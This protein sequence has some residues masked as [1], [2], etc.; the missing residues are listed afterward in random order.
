M[1]LLNTFTHSNQPTSYFALAG[2]GIPIPGPPGP[3]G[4]QG[5]QGE[6]GLSVLSGAG[7]P[8]PGLGVVGDHYID[9]NTSEFYT[10]T[11]PTTWTSNFYMIG[12]TGQPG[13][14]ATVSVGLTTTVAPGNPANVNNTGTA[15]NAILNFAI[16]QGIQGPVGPQ[17]P[18]GSPATASIWSTFPATQDVDIG[19]HQLD[20]VTAINAPVGLGV[21]APT[22]NITLEV[23]DPSGT[24]I[25]QIKGGAL[26]L[27]GNDV[28]DVGSFTAGGISES[29]TFG[30]TI[31]PMLNHSVY[32]TNVSV[33][34]YNPISAMNFIGV[35]GVNINAPDNDINLNAGDI[36]LTQTQGTS[37]MNLTAVGG[38]VLGAGAGIDLTGGGAIAINAG[39]TIQIVSTGNVSIGSGNVLGADTEVEK[40]SFK[41]NEMY[42]NGSVDLIMSDIQKISN[43]STSLVIESVG[44]L[45]SATGDGVLIKTNGGVGA[46]SDVRIANIGGDCITVD[47]GTGLTTFTNATS[48]PPQCAYVAAVGND[49]TNKSYV[50]TKI[51]T[52]ISAASVNY[53]PSTT[54]IS[55]NHD[56]GSPA[57]SAASAGPYI[58]VAGTT[59]TPTGVPTV[60]P[61]C[62][63]VYVDT[64][65]GGKLYA[66]FSGVWNAI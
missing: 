18:P 30:A 12:P 58:Q 42:R 17:G 64:T 2:S 3:Q 36:N 19:N 7:L 37:F 11:D 44:Q 39:G 59:G 55:L 60:I 49:L 13:Q 47:A 15:Q 21:V 29:A 24:P 23:Q 66:F 38:I 31:A 6:P 32:A 63:P 20:N 40:F 4:P 54:D 10:K 52:D 34:S 50:D 8:V 51:T 28:K 16:P 5:P 26:D 35:G 62:V 22:G 25:V 9:L 45:L 14:A 41:D 57:A 27:D 33:N 46:G 53:L 56:F 43:G 65:G 1:S 61:G 48:A